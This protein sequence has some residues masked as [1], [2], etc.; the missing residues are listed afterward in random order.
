MSRTRL[1][2]TRAWIERQ[3][4]GGPYGC[5]I[6]RRGTL[7][8]EWYGGGLNAQSLFEIGSIRKSFNSALIGI[9]LEQGIVDL[10]A[11]A[12]AWWPELVALS[13]DSADETITLH[14]LASAVSGWRTPD[15]PG[16][17]WRYNNAAFTACER[18]VAR[19]YGLAGDEIAGEVA[20]RFKGPLGASSWNVYHFARAFS[21]QHGARLAF[22]GRQNRAG[23]GLGAVGDDLLDP[24]RTVHQVEGAQRDVDAGDA[25]RLARDDLRHGHG[26]FGNGGVARQVARAA[27]VLRQ[28]RTHGVFVHDARQAA[29]RARR[30]PAC[31]SPRLAPRTH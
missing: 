1:E 30:R 8:T 23:G 24:G 14:Q 19:M 20:R 22:N 17:A 29:H 9:G 10:D 15:A 4:C 21:A 16:A 26:V 3:T 27:Q 7:A 13:G 6:A 11:R 12:A 18:V 31:A 2:E 28:R 5:L 25:A